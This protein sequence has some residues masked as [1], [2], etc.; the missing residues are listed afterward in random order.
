M[1]NHPGTTLITRAYRQERRH[2]I[3]DEKKIKVK[4]WLY[5]MTPLTRPCWILGRN[6]RRSGNA[7]RLRWPPSL[8][9]KGFQPEI[10]CRNENTAT[11]RGVLVQPLKTLNQKRVTSE[12]DIALLKQL[13]SKNLEMEL[14]LFNRTML[15]SK[16]IDC[17]LKNND[18][19]TPSM[20]MKHSRSE[21][22]SILI[23]APKL[24]KST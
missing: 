16:I 5:L 17:R 1:Y 20:T 11:A 21:N 10:C 12:V 23:I 7:N 2:A 9:G 24:V 19:T 18:A 22:W 4:E 3:V 15:Q 14:R 8:T 13:W 6:V